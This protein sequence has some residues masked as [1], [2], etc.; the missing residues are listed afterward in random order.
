MNIEDIQSI[1]KKFPGMKEDIKWENH[2]CFNVGDKMFLV[3][4]P[5]TVPV[6][7]S[8]KACDEDFE[9]LPS[10]EGFKPAPYLA[11]AKWIFVDD[12]N[13]LTK[14]EWQRIIES[15]YRLVASKLTVK[16]KKQINF[17]S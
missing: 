11:R 10:R 14:K 9:E 8:F 2:L 12:I 3:T 13:R 4:S 1:C 16:L 6:T 5:D 15:A 7:A 17:Q